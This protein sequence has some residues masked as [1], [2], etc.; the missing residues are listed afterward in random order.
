MAIIAFSGL[1]YFQRTKLKQMS[2]DADPPDTA[3]LMSSGESQSIPESTALQ[4]DGRVYCSDMLSKAEAEF[5]I[6]NCP[7]TKMDG[8]ND[9]EPCEND[10]RF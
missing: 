2:P 3:G 9:G 7:G 4:C 1:G 5:F 8:D 10:S 6:N